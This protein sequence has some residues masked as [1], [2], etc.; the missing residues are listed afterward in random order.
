MLKE[1][2]TKLGNSQLTTHENSSNFFFNKR[3]VYDESFPK[4][5]VIFY[6]TWYEI[7]EQQ[8]VKENQVRLVWHSS[9]HFQIPT[10]DQVVLFNAM[11]T[12]LSFICRY[13]YYF[14]HFPYTLKLF[15]TQILQTILHMFG[16][17]P[18]TREFSES[19]K[20]SFGLILFCLAE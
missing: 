11:M 12:I 3:T 16:K 19:L 6:K 20:L 5:H 14:F 18:E 8:V 10:S 9:F 17:F 4:H 1:Q 13:L 7:E 2:R 15:Q